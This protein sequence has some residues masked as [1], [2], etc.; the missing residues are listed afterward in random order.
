MSYFELA[1]EYVQNIMGNYYWKLSEKIMTAKK[2]KMAVRTLSK[3]LR[4][5]TTDKLSPPYFEKEE[6]VEYY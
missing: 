5:R 6:G 4:Y 1:T 2:N 3:E